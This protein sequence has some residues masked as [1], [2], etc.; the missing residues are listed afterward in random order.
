M[1]RTRPLTLSV[2]GGIRFGIYH[3]L[4]VVRCCDCN[5]DKVVGIVDIDRDPHGHISDK[6]L[7]VQMKKICF[8]L[9]F[10]L[11]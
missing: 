3:T 11:R 6:A 10:T 2:Y 5:E 8:C 9:T 7:L 1:T 4:M